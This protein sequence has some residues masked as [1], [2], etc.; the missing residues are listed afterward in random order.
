M[1]GPRPRYRRLARGR[2]IGIGVPID[3]E[4]GDL[5]L[6]NR[7]AA[8]RAVEVWTQSGLSSCLVLEYA[9]NFGMGFVRNPDGKV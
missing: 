9:G 4:P 7:G 6:G 2:M 8:A 3:A 5:V 1:M